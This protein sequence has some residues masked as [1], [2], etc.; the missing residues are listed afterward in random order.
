MKKVKKP[1]FFVVLALLIAFGY[2]VIFGVSNQYG[3]I[4]TTY[5]KG[6]ETIRWGIDI[7][8][9]VNVTF[10]PADNYD[11]EDYQMEDAEQI[12][13]QRL[14]GLGITDYEVY[15][16]VNKD[17]LIVQFPWKEGE[18]DFDPEAAVQE[19]GATAM[20]TFREGTGS[21]ENG[22]PTGEIIV[23]GAEVSRAYVSLNETNEYVVALE[24][25]Q[26]GSRKFAEATGRLVG[27]STPIS[28]WMDETMI[29]YPSVN[30]AITDGKAVISGNFN[31]DSA[32]TLA[33]QINS[34]ALPFKLETTSFST[35]SPSLGLGARDAMI[36]SG[37]IAFVLIMVLMVVLYRLPG[38]VAVLGLAGQV[39]GM[40]AAITGYF[41]FYNGSTLTIPGIAGIILSIG[42]GVDANVITFERIKEELRLGKSLD[43]AIQSGYSRALSAI[44]DGNV[45]VI[46]VAIILMGSFG[47]TDSFFAKMLQWLFF[48]FGPSTAGTVYSFGFTLL[49]GVLLN[50]VFGVLVS[51]LLL[52]S[53]SKFK[54]FRNPVLYGGVKTND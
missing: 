33:N 26:E 50:F 32:A 27:T 22:S 9:G 21:D 48:A 39:C 41:A 38:A 51:R 40:L 13:K 5:I 17:R 53:L 43:S 45:T 3:D 47:P 37:A 7:R 2:T 12:I 28:I 49:S 30:Q 44:V 29:S 14:V 42:M 18:T 35:V 23:Q 16:D 1:V 31:A 52:A 8:G 36:L 4:A 46:I 20:L 11:A 10:T 6:I 19:L 15:V 34:G 54:A 24:F 25:S